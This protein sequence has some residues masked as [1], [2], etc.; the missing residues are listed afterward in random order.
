MLTSSCLGFSLF[1]VDRIFYIE[2]VS[3]KLTYFCYNIG[4]YIV[5]GG[6]NMKTVKVIGCL[7]LSLFVIGGVLLNGL[8]RSMEHITTDELVGNVVDQISTQVYEKAI[9]EQ[10]INYVPQDIQNQVAENLPPEA[11]EKLAGVAPAEVQQKIED[12]KQNIINDPVIAALADKYTDAIING[13]VSGDTTLPDVNADIQNVVNEHAD[14]LLEPLGVSLS[15]EQKQTLVK[16]VSEKI[17]LQ[18]Y[19]EETVNKVH[20]QLTPSQKQ[21]LSMIQFMTSNT[22]EMLSYGLIIGGLL[23][24]A[25]L[26]FS[27]Y[28]W[29]SYGGVSLLA[30]GCCL[31]LVSVV[32]N[33]LF[34]SEIK[35][36][37][38]SFA[39]LGDSIFASLQS[40]GLLF[41]G[42]GL[43]MII[44]YYIANYIA[45]HVEYS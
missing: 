22:M 24:I 8:Y 20:E 6:F 4:K 42:I 14:T 27:V 36:L 12:A 19:V 40:S 23:C 35:K 9:T 17:D 21:M 29:L 32:G 25:L 2:F 37:G 13:A 26:R 43:V 41:G 31:Y 18:T 33:M 16:Q 11:Q 44:G 38:D 34:G 7:V 15:N 28:R 10:I 3:V 30:G 1:Y 5:V 45:A 39:G